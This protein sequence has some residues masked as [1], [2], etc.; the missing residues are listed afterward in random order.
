MIDYLLLIW[1]LIG[2]FCLGFYYG[3]KFRKIAEE[4]REIVERE[5]KDGK[6]D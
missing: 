5:M 4:F 1:I 3:Y 6:T 2:I